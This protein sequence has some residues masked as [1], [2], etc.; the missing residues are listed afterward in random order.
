VV[1]RKDDPYS[2]LALVA[3]YP[4]ELRSLRVWLD[5]GAEDGLKAGVANLAADLTTAE[6]P[7]MFERWPGG[8]NRPY[9]CS[10]TADYLA[11]YTALWGQ[12]DKG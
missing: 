8:H 4:A 1:G 5:V 6:I 12:G 9:W 2:P 3:A 11:F 10:H 7:T